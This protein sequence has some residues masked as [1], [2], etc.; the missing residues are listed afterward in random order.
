M[1]VSEVTP[2]PRAP[3]HVAGVIHHLGRVLPLVDLRPALGLP[4]AAGAGEGTLALLLDVPPWYVAA[5]V[6][7][8]IGF[9]VSRAFPGRKGSA[10]GTEEMRVLAKGTVEQ[11]GHEYA[12]LD[13]WRLMESIRV[14]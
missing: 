2:V 13:A 1:P 10:S 3:A 9:E 6:D 14:G 11:D 12:L 4:A 5:E 7:E 8:V